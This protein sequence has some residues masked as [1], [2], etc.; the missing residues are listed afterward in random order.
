MLKAGIKFAT[1]DLASKFSIESQ[2]ENQPN[3]LQSSFGFH[4]KRWLSNYY[5]KE[6][7][8]KSNYSREYSSLLL[9]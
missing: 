4:G 8:I 7:A 9:S 5:L 1:L 3:S 6:L 2:V